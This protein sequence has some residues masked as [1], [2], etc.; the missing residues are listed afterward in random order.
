VDLLF[1]A[2]TRFGRTVAHGMLLYSLLSGLAGKK[3][4]GATQIYAEFIFRAP[5]YTGQPVTFSLVP[6]VETGTGNLLATLNATVTGKDQEPGLEGKVG[7]LN[8]PYRLES[9][10]QAAQLLTK[11]QK[12]GES[13]LEAYKG[14]QLGQRAVVRR[15]FS[16]ADLEEY[17]SLA[18]D[19]NP[20]Y[21][22][23]AFARSL[24][25]AD[26]PLPGPLLGGCSPTC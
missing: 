1:S 12:T 4:P 26:T 15:R 21:R 25:L 17:C 7:L 11:T 20:L 18:S 10:L 8:T 16:Q 3:H 5:T 14:L 22:D 24:G 13:T 19:P 23:P 6:E 2:R 9:W